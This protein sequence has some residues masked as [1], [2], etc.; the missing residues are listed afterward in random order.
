MRIMS[1]RT[2][3]RPLVH[4]RE[5]AGAFVASMKAPKDAIFS[6][7]V[8][9]GGDAE[10]YQ[11]RDV[12]D[13]VQELVPS[14]EVEYTGEVGSDPRNYRVRFGLLSSVLPDFKLQYTLKSGMHELC[15]KMRAHSFSAADFEGE[16]L[17]RLR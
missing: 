6:R 17:V 7:A 4:C 2:P 9:I 13:V 10:D 5:I 8:N 15:D 1:G 14:A 11:V 12:A 16:Q 3:W